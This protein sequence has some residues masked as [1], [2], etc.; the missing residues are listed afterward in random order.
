[1]PHIAYCL[2]FR[3]G[4][5]PVQL[6]LAYT[7]SGTWRGGTRQLPHGV[8]EFDAAAARTLNQSPFHIDL[9]CLARVPLSSDWFPRLLDV[10]YGIVAWAKPELQRRINQLMIDVARRS[11]GN[12]EMRGVPDG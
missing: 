10:T 4:T 8:I 5:V 9:R 3:T 11:P 1:M 6:M 12:I 7:S 2:G